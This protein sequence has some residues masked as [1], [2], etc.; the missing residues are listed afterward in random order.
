ML[1]HLVWTIVTGPVRARGAGVVPVLLTAVLVVVALAA[2]A[3]V[4]LLGGRG[5]RD[6]QVPLPPLAVPTGRAT[7]SEVAAATAAP[8]SLPTTAGGTA[9][10]AGAVQAALAGPLTD[11]RLGGRTLGQV[12]DLGSGATLYSVGPDT[13]VAPASTAKIVTA[14]AVLSVFARDHRVTTTVVAGPTPGAVT[15]VG[16]GDPTLSAAPAG[17]R[18]PYAGAARITDLAA[19]VQA[20]LAGTAVTAVYVDGAAFTGPT[21]AT[22]W[23]PDDAPSP[24]GAPITA[25]MVDGGRD[26]PDATS[27]RAPPTSRRGR[28]WPRRSACR[29]SR[30]TQI[31]P[32]PRPA[33][34][35]W[36]RCSRQRSR[37]SSRRCSRS[38][39]TSSPRC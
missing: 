1:S 5:L 28:P 15:L 22:G 9:P 19:A 21:T 26:T 18:T 13:G 11:P 39:T 38:P 23:A 2:G 31:R 36:D 17:H 29:T 16:A 27:G 10:T 7:P 8:A 32:R 34:R 33:A 4:G 6:A 12:V 25:A 20:S 35:S 24:Y 37:S 14:A 30:C 3:L